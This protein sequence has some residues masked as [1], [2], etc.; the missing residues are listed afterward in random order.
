MN[1]RGEG[2]N[3]GKGNPVSLVV[4]KRAF[5]GSLEAFNELEGA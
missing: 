5:L 1:G 2:G 4:G 3:E